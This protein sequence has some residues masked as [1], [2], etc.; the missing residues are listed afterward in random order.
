VISEYWTLAR[1]R[2]NPSGDLLVS[3]VNPPSTD[4]VPS[5]KNSGETSS[6]TNFHLFVSEGCVSLSEN[7][8]TVTVKILCDTGATQSLL[9]DSTLPLSERT[10]IGASVLIQGIGLDMINV[11]LHQIFQLVS[12][13]V[14]VGIRP[15]LPIEGISLILG[16]NL[17]GGRV[18]PDPQIISNPSNVLS[19][20]EG[21]AQTF[22]VCVVI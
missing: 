20:N 6:S 5:V 15:T 9:V 22:P 10:S 2:S 7:G 12:G 21:P 17:A 3:T 11:P 1:K 19:D 8:E 4:R 14:I 13:P 16:N 18:Q